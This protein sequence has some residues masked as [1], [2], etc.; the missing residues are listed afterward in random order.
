MK[1]CSPESVIFAQIL[2]C[3]TQSNV[4][5]VTK[6]PDVCT[7]P[8]SEGEAVIFVVA[9]AAH[10]GARQ[11]GEGA[12][13]RRVVRDTVIVTHWQRVPS[14]TFTW[15]EKRRIVHNCRSDFFRPNLFIF[16]V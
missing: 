3:S 15:L 6:E 12:E 10:P 9:V 2:I 14:Y 7:A 13:T 16:A 8:Q 5:H 11:A 4:A 1:S